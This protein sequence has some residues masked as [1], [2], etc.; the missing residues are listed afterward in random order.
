MASVGGVKVQIPPAGTINVVGVP[1]V[2]V[3]RRVV[4][5]SAVPLNVGVES[6]VKPPEAMEPVTGDTLSVTLV[7]TGVVG[8]MEST[9]RLN[10]AVGLS[11]P[12]A[13]IATK[14]KA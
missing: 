1:L 9:V 3:M 6:L 5:A 8:A 2:R 14:A 7:I 13:S 10:V 4:P 11:L 12:A